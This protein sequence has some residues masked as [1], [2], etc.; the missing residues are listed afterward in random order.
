MSLRCRDNM[1]ME[2]LA[3][4]GQYISKLPKVKSQRHYSDVA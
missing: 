1:E 4:D 3:M 2:P